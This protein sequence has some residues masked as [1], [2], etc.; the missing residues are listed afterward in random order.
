MSTEFTEK[1]P[2]R[3]PSCQSTHSI[4]QTPTLPPMTLSNAIRIYEMTRFNDLTISIPEVMIQADYDSLF[5]YFAYELPFILAWRE[6]E[7]RND[8]FMNQQRGLP[9][10]QILQYKAGR[11]ACLLY[12]KIH[13]DAPMRV[14]S[15]Y[16]RI[17]IDLPE[18]EIQEPM[19]D[20]PLVAPPQAPVTAFSYVRGQAPPGTY[21]H[22]Y[23][24][25]GGADPS[26]SSGGQ[27]AQPLQPP[28]VPQRWTLPRHPALPRPPDPPAHWILT[29]G[30]VTPYEDFKPKVLK[31]VNDFN[32]DSNDISCF[33]LKCEL[34]FDLFNR[35]FRYHPHKVI[36]CVSQLK[37][38]AEKWWELCSRIIGEN[39]D[40][41]QLYPSY[42]DFQTELRG[43]FW[44]NADAQIKHAQWE[45]LRQSSYQDG[46]QFFQKFEE[47]AYDTG[48]HD[49]GY[50]HSE[51]SGKV[52]PMQSAW[53][54]QT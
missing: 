51:G 1:A 28:V 38:D 31:E 46:D 21:T 5:R 39:D 50:Q 9:S 42:E 22:S 47:L 43:R 49:N 52:F 35:H 19:P 12:N 6:I 15:P 17:T 33:F 40:R 20:K 27:P 10:D 2:S 48:V 41:E 32:G 36:F 37:G 34:H 23:I 29:A 45:K 13:R 18:I 8:Y 30:N 44:K 3:P 11:N 24:P 53:P 25:F 7:A 14:L 4:Q 16:R 54:L 26:G